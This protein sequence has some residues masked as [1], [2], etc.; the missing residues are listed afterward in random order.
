MDATFMTAGALFT[1]GLERRL[2]HSPEKV[3]RASR[4]LTQPRP[5]PLSHP[6]FD[7]LTVALDGRRCWP[8]AV[9][10]RTDG[11]PPPTAPSLKY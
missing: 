10:Q 6:G 5:K 2:A 9:L 4:P 11:P 3:W 7:R 8:E 1:L